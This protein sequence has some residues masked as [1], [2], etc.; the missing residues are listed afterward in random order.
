[1][2]ATIIHLSDLHFRN[3]AANRHRLD[4]LR[5]DLERLQTDEPLHT[6]FTGDLVYAGDDNDFGILLDELIG[7]LLE[8]GHEIFVVPGNHDVQ[9]AIANQPFTDSILKDHTSSYLFAGRTS[10]R[11]D[12]PKAE[13][14]ALVNYRDFEDLFEPYDQR[15]Y[16]GYTATRGSVSVL[17]LNSAWLCCERPQGSTD[18]G[19]LRIEPSVLEKL[20]KSLPSETLRIALLHHP[21][22]WLE[23]TTR[24]AVNDLLIKH[25]DLVL[26][27]HVHAKDVIGQIKGSSNCLFFQ[28]PP[29]RADWS[30][31]TNGYAIIHSDSDHKYFEVEYRSYSESRRAFVSGEDFTPGGR[32]YPRHEDAEFFKRTPSRSS[33]LQRLLRAEPIDYLDWYRSHVRSKSKV[34]GSF[35]VPKAHHIVLAEEG[36][37]YSPPQEVTQIV[38]NSKRDQFFIAPLDAGS[39]TA[40][41]LTFKHL[42]ETFSFHRLVPAYFDAG[43]ETINK[44][45]ILRKISQTTPVPYSHL[46]TEQ[47]AAEGMI[48]VVVDGLC[49]GDVEQFNLFR[50]TVD[51]HLTEIRFIYFLSTERRGISPTG[52]G[53]PRL[54]PEQ[55]EVFEFAQLDVDDIRS[56]VSMR[57]PDRAKAEAAREVFVNHV[58]QSFRQMDEP[59]FASTVAVVIDTIIQDPEFKPLN[60]ARLIE[61]Y[62]E[63]LLGRFDLEDVREGA[64]SSSSKITFL[65]FVAR[66]LLEAN[67]V[68]MDET[69]WDEIVSSYQT[70]FW[71][72]LPRGLLAEFFEKG[73]LTM[74]GG[75]ITFRG[76]HLFSF[77]IAQEMKRDPGFAASLVQ[78]RGLFRH[79]REI[80]VYGELEGTN[81]ADVLQVVFGELGAIETTLLENYSREG[82]TLTEEW[83]ATCAETASDG[84]SRSLR[85]AAVGLGQANATIEEADRY[86]N[87]EL[88]QINRRRGV[89]ERQEV[90]EAEARLLVG[91][92]LYGLLLKNALHLEG[93]EKLRHLEKLYE[94]AELWVGFMCARRMV[95]GRH[96]FVVSGGVRFINLGAAIDPEKSY[97]DFKFDAPNA[98][99]RVIV[100]TMHNPQLS[101]AIR[102]LIG[103]LDPMSKL[104]AR[105]VL[106]EMPGD[107]NRNAFLTSL[108]AETDINLITCAL[109]TLRSRYLSAG[110]NEERRDHL[111]KIVE[112]IA[113][114]PRVGLNVDFSKL[115]KARLVQDLKGKAGR[116]L[117]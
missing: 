31:G 3:D 59:I 32:L 104:F 93:V 89:A 37:V 7:P 48:V 109:R 25:T 8:M 40:A 30:K 72:D 106:L 92:R 116:S 44:A 66:Q 73:L 108:K 79:Y 80:T 115:K 87:A 97:R 85:E 105:N 95:I 76:D 52:I 33:L 102:N 86:D 34:T 21:I 35:I 78:G 113:K 14:D 46:E 88:T 94:A 1:M 26:F 60:K 20:A 5:T 83:K 17:G 68:G 107:K 91:M 38:N 51:R 70:R 58:V 98:V 45:S 77:F 6:V 63:C 61:R 54:S 62:V 74:E 82:I 18:R 42:S 117:K 75:E 65:G 69:R 67:R 101:I 22:D 9:R 114:D 84:A 81:I 10:I 90:R 57:V 36:P 27:G 110:R 16:W 19:A 43:Q 4:C 111:E 64:F 12:H 100:D 47:L 53:E 15:S 96:P 29:L 56:M 13:F 11:T 23:E 50:D 55:D 2:S 71:I 41:Y 49:L 39:T 28:A 24:S 103:K 112:E 99:S